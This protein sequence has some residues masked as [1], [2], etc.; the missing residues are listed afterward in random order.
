MRANNPAHGFYCLIPNSWHAAAAVV[1][2][3]TTQT[4]SG[5]QYLWPAGFIFH[6]GLIMCTVAYFHPTTQEKPSS[7]LPLIAVPVINHTPSRNSFWDATGNYN[8][9]SGR[10]QAASEHSTQHTESDCATGGCT[11]TPL[12][13]NVIETSLMHECNW[14]MPKG[15][16]IID[17]FHSRSFNS[18]TR[19]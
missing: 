15:Y 14:Q 5:R 17:L 12:H 18:H 13:G 16:L 11:P 10:P 1:A 9:M 8:V 6:S 3:A 4:T 19:L 7:L 2:F